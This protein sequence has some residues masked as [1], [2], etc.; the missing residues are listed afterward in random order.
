MTGENPEKAPDTWP[1]LALRSRKHDL[2]PILGSTRELGIMIQY[3]VSGVQETWPHIYN[4]DILLFQAF[5]PAVLGFLSSQN[6]Q[7]ICWQLFMF[8]ATKLTRLL[9]FAS[10]VD[11]IG[12]EV[13]GASHYADDI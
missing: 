8:K 10:G 5:I 12:K 2:G 4:K 3:L 11:H 9:L 13:V 1:N 6:V 7:V